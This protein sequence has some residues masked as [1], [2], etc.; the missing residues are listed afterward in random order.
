MPSQPLDDF[1]SYYVIESDPDPIG[2]F[3]KGA[4]LTAS[5]AEAMLSMGSFTDGTTI[6]R[7]YRGA[8]QVV[9]RDGPVRQVLAEV[10]R[11]GG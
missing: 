2:G 6:R 7:V 9:R 8:L 4:K 5:S 3:S 11:A 1:D 10:G